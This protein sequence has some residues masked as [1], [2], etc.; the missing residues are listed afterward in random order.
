MR[1]CKDR[2]PRFFSPVCWL[3]ECPG[4]ERRGPAVFLE[5][6]EVGVAVK[7][8]EQTFKVARY[9]VRERVDPGAAESVEWDP[10]SG[11]AVEMDVSPPLFHGRV[12]RETLCNSEG[13][14]AAK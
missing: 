4:A 14:V 12:S 1:Q 8:Q 13:R 9:C 10:F 5:I 2:G 11:M 7:F 3:V 6:D